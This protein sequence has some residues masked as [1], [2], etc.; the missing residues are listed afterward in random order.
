MKKIGD[1]VVNIYCN[2]LKYV[3]IDIGS[4]YIYMNPEPMSVFHGTCTKALPKE[5]MAKYYRDNEE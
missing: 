1:K 2:E 3:I 4:V 5:D